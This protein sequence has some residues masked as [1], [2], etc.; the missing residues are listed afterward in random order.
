MAKA[1][2]AAPATAAPATTKTP[3]EAK[4]AKAKIEQ[5]GVTRPSADST[6]G[7]VWAIADKISAKLKAPAPRRD[8]LAETSALGINDATAA[9]QYGKW[10]KFNGLKSE[11]KAKVA[12]AEPKAKG[13]A[14]QAAASAAA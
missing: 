7:K 8:V 10:R 5:N 12:P 2:P 3:K 11:P 14:K 9:T 1:K 6:T 13:K 4:P